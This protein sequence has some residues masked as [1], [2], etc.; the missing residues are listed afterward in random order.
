MNADQPRVRRRGYF[1]SDSGS[2]PE[3]SDNESPEGISYIRNSRPRRAKV[4]SATGRRHRR[5]APSQNTRSN[6]RQARGA[7]RATAIG[8]RQP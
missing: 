8:T 2:G 5:T 4:V 3:V 6:D 1:L 7:R